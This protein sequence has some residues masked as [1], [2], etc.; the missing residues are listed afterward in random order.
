[1]NVK[2]EKQKLLEDKLSSLGIKK[3]DVIEKFIKSSGPGGQ[4]VNKVRTAVYLKHIPSQIEV[5]AKEGRT[6]ALN[7]FLAWRLLAQKYEE[8]VLGLKSPRIKN[9]EKIR[10]QKKN[11]HRK[12]RIKINTMELLRNS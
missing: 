2:P 8:I 1:M 7:R 12:A 3:T 6:Q 4:N 10:K 5:K 9:I 11:R